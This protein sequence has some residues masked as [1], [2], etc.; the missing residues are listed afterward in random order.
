[1]GHLLLRP[2]HSG[3]PPIQ[4][5]FNEGVFIMKKIL[6]TLV[7]LLFTVISAFPAERVT[8]HFMHD[9]TGATVDQPTWVTV[10][11]T[12]GSRAVW[13]YFRYSSN[14]LY[15]ERSGYDAFTAWFDSSTITTAN[16][17]T[18][19]VTLY[20]MVW[21]VVSEAYEE[22]APSYAAGDTIMQI[23]VASQFKWRTS[24]TDSKASLRKTLNLPA[25]IDAVKCVFGTNTAT[26]AYKARSEIRTS[27]AR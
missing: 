1:M 20:Y 8:R 19:N 9:T 17:D 10:D 25:D 5:D 22:F 14:H 2:I 21:D 27:E 12:V 26:N 6:F 11:S 13:F 4:R 23:P 3:L 15:T 7:I 16:D 18:I 24:H